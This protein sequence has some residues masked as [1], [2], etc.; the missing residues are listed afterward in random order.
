MPALSD[1]SVG[2]NTF[3]YVY[4][5]AMFDSNA[6]EAVISQVTLT[7]DGLQRTETGSETTSGA[8]SVAVTFDTPFNTA[9]IL[10][11]TPSGTGDVTASYSSLT[12]TGFTAHFKSGGVTAAGTVHWTA[13]G[14]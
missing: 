14:V 1:L 4:F 3:R 10:Q 12:T 11:L 8:G 9:P 2:T 7:I 5:A 13:T 6:G